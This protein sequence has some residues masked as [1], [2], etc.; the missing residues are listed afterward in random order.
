M[1][2]TD[3]MWRTLVRVTRVGTDS[4]D[5]IIPG[6]DVRRNVYVYKQGIPPYIFKR[7]KEGDRLHAQCNIGANTVEELCFDRWEDE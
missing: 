6:W 3:R 2:P 1:N 7:M 5:V 4:I